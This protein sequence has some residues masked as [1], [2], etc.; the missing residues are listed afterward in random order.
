MSIRH[1]LLALLADHDAYGYQLRSRFESLTGSVWPLNIGQV[2]TTLARLERDGLVLGTGTGDDGRAMYHLTEAG[3]AELQSWWRSPVS[4]NDR[5]RDE[6]AIKIAL[7][8][9][10][11]GVDASAIL[12]TQRLDTMRAMQDLTRL[13]RHADVADLPWRLVLESMIFAAEAEIRWLDHCESAVIR[14]AVQQ[15]AVAPI[16]AAPAENSEV[17]S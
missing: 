16:A 5:P 3:Q 4:R 9:T 13:K 15:R 6:L 12:Q 10:A 17:S 11:T 7:A 14:H 8:V 1:S 2:Y